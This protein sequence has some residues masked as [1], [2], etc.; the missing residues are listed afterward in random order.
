MNISSRSIPLVILLLWSIACFAQPTRIRGIVIDKIT[1]EP[2]PF[3]NV[4]LKGTTIGTITSFDGTFFL[5]T[6]SPTDSLIASYIGYKPA[7]IKINNGAYQD[8][9]ILLETADITLNEVVV[10]AGENPAHRFLRGINENKEKNNPDRIESYTYEIYNKM[11]LDINNVTEE[12]KNKKAFK[13]FQ[14]IFDY[15]DTSAVTGKTFLPVFIVE[16]LSDFYYQKQPSK[17]KEKI[18]ANNVSGVENE[19]FSEFTGQMYLDFNIYSNHLPIMG[20]D[21]VSPIARFGLLYYKYYLIDSAYRDNSWCYNI[22]FKPKRKQEPTFTGNFWVADTTFAVQSFKIQMAE[23]M[24]I[25]FIKSFIAEQSFKKVE[26]SIWFPKKQELFIDFAVTNKEYGFFGRKTTSYSNIVLRPTFEEKFFSGQ[27]SEELIKLDSASE[28]SVATWDSLR[29]EKLSEQEKDIYAMVDSIK[30]VPLYQSIITLINTFVTGYW[31]KGPVEIG[32]YYTMYSFNPIEG[33]R[34]RLGAQT[35]NEVSTTVQYGGHLAYGTLDNEFKYGLRTLYI[36]NKN[37]RRAVFGSY[38]NDYEQLGITSYAFLSD[39]ILSSILARKQNDKL[40][41]V[42]STTLYYEHEWFQGVSNTITFNNKFIYPS[43]TVPFNY[44]RPNDTLSY[45]YLASTEIKLNARFAYNEKF[46]LGE[47]NRISLGTKFPIVNI[48]LTAGV[49]GLFQG[50]FEYYKVDFN[51][52]DKIRVNPFGTLKYTIDAG[53]IF[54]NAPFPF[55][56]LHEGNQ[57]YAFDDY[58]FNLMN[59]YEFVSDTYASLMIENH[60][61]GTFLNHVPL[62]R[63]LKWREVAAFK[64]VYGEIDRPSV[65]YVDF[66]ETLNELKTPYMEA[67]VGIENIFKFFRVDAVWRLTHLDNPEA[68]PFGIFAKMQIRF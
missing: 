19:S 15:V 2:I 52:E 34:F 38:K 31:I 26:D 42:S 12:Y 43:L 9:K 30:E 20:Q 8:L 18:K 61:M 17:K 54:G 14:F 13:H 23:D 65:N 29:H 5:E 36:F 49:K 55:L 7:K 41:K 53:K 59:Y 57:T 63:K 62:F 37:P 47:F 39:N 1:S 44:V 48:N 46:L 68:M 40:T 16:T 25:N 56:Q 4:A 50:E 11:E 60:F 24:N 45:N 58:A 6:R 51:V 32:P 22:S 27:L 33:N 67:G 66:P 10:V 35:S 21:L 64:I 28:V 3:V